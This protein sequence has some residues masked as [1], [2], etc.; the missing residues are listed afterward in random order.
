[1]RVVVIRG[2]KLLPDKDFHK[3]SVHDNNVVIGQLQ[4]PH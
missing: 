1:M 4:T 3:T 2:Q